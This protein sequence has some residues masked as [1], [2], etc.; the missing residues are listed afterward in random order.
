MRSSH[1]K[2][3]RRRTVGVVSDMQAKPRLVRS[4]RWVRTLVAIVDKPP[5]MKRGISSSPTCSA[6]HLVRHGFAWPIVL[7]F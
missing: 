7:I 1:N 5:S 2:A 4:E 3:E 6:I